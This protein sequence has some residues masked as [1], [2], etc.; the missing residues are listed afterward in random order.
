MGEDCRTRFNGGNGFG[1]WVSQ[2]DVKPEGDF[3][4]DDLGVGRQFG[5]WGEEEEGENGAEE[6]EG[7]ITP[8][9]ERAVGENRGG[10]FDEAGF[11]ACGVPRKLKELYA[12]ADGV[13][14]GVTRL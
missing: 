11:F 2:F 10:G 12:G 7:F 1:F 14:S 3:C 9:L 8:E 6:N 5:V 13:S 4:I